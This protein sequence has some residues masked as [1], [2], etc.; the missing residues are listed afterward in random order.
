MI[1]NDYSPAPAVKIQIGGKELIE[2]NDRLI[3]LTLT[4][5]RGFEADTLDLTLDDTDGKVE[6]PPRGA[7]ISVSLGWNNRPLVF[8]GIY[9][10]DEVAHQGPPD[11]LVIS[12]RS[13][14]FRETFN[15]KRD[16]SWHDIKVGDVVAAIASRY[17][18]Q[19]GVSEELATVEIDHADQTNE[20]DIS[21]LTRMAEMLG[22]VATI[23]NGMILFILPGQ[24]VSQS[25]KRLPIITITRES[26]DKHN[27]R[28][29][30]R[31]AYTGVTAYWLDLN[32]GKPQKVSIKRKKKTPPQ[33]KEKSTSKEGN[34]L[35]GEEGNVYVMRKTYKTEQAANR[36]AAAKWDEL[37]RGAAVFSINLDRGR[38][39]L[40]PDQ[41]A[42]V[43][44]FKSA[45]DAGNWTITRC[46]HDVGGS[47]FTTS[48][49]L[50]VRLTEWGTS[51][52]E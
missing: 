39:D 46:V 21:F 27:F 16:Y 29:A 47:G 2:L 10:V 5:N 7:K 20:S 48:L 14:D 35:A 19:A 44:G 31:D 52:E 38:A 50:E 32:F 17:E 30:D 25:G 37:Q 40:F 3:C 45:I 6:L 41:P 11:Q 15:V 33:N 36:A 12:A 9:T 8:K 28:I 4:D 13:A 23:K 51:D 34:Y 24:G 49:E 18:L 1:D 26:G 42:I 43:S 22:A